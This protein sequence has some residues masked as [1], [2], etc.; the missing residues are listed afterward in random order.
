MNLKHR[1]PVY[2]RL[3]TGACFQFVVM[4]HTTEYKIQSEQEQQLYSFYRDIT[5]MKPDNL[6]EGH[7]F[8][9]DPERLLWIGAARA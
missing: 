9:R 2:V 1:I 6:T 5:R 4:T 7:M 8:V 3:P